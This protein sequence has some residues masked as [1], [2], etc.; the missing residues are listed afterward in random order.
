MRHADRQ[1]CDE[2]VLLVCSCL[3]IFGFAWA[4]VGRPVLLDEQ[5]SYVFSY[6]VV[7][8]VSCVQGLRPSSKCYANLAEN[9]GN[10]PD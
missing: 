7:V 8:A 5:T 6:R 10:T 1:R 3:V 2:R 9:A 4:I